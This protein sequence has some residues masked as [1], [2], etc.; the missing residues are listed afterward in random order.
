[1]KKPS[2]QAIRVRPLDAAALPTVIG[3]EGID[4]IVYK[5]H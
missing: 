5:I 4:V 3:G 2:K 1:M